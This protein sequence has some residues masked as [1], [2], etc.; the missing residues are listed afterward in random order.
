MSFQITESEIKGL[1]LIQS[2]VFADDRGLYKKNFEKEV[3]AQNGITCQFTE[4]SDIYSVKGALRGLHYQTEDSQAK[5]IHVISGTLFDVALD[6]RPDSETFGK[7]HAELLTG[8]SDRSLFIREGFAHGFNALTDRTIFSYQC[9]GRYIPQACGGVRWDSPELN[10]PWPL[11]EYGI[12]DIIATEKDRNWPT[13]R[14]YVEKLSQAANKSTE[15][16]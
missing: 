5:L 16:K 8:E 3:F 7:Y 13:F 4:C 6:L 11:G 15:E 14:Q 1:Y 2:H 10:I 9:S 12:T